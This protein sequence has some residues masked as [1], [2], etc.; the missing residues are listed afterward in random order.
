[1][2]LALNQRIRKFYDQSTPLWLQVWGEHMHHGFYGED[3]REKKEDRQAQLD[4]MKTLLRWGD[5]DRAEKVLDA[6]CGVGGSARYLASRL[7]SQVYGVTLSPIQAERARVY[8]QEAGLLDRVEI[9]TRDMLTLSPDDGPF[10]LIW[11]LESA[12]HVA[13]KPGL[14]RV[15]HEAA[16][17][18][19]RLLMA[20]WCRRETPPELSAGDRRMLDRIQKWYHLPPLCS[21]GQ[22]EQAARGAGFREIELADWSRAVAPFWGAVIRSALDWRS[23]IGLFK[24]GAAT[25]RG[26]WSM[27]YMQRGFRR[28]LIR[29]VVLKACKP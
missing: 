8:N 27:Q 6:G 20:T 11:S 15:F 9:E 13:D 10:D 25:W 7:G 19:G 5:I 29:F 16:R 21:P 2:P 23:L 14:F 1:M 12:E 24:A 3:G 26:A 28:G 4:L 17:P 22:L 18:G